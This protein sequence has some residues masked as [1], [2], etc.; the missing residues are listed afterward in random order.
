MI[1]LAGYQT[2]EALTADDLRRNLVPAKQDG[3]G[4]SL[5]PRTGLEPDVESN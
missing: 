3:Q 2:R 1:F 5:R 4:M